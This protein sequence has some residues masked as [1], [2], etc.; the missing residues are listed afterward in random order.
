MLSVLTF[1]GLRISELLALRWRDVDLAAGWLSVAESKTDAGRRRV[2]V[3]GAL[4]DELLRVRAA[5]NHVDQDGYVF[6][7]RTG[8]RLGPDNFRNRVLAPA[9]KRANEQL[10]KRERPY[11]RGSRRTR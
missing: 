9:Q 1:A 2:K 7:T 6:P 3:R 8:A 4:R 11:C 5:H 10:A